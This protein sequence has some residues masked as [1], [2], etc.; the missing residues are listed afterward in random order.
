MKPMTYPTKVAVPLDSS[1]GAMLDSVCTSER[2]SRPGAL[3]NALAFY[4]ANSAT[5]TE[6]MRKALKG[7]NHGHHKRKNEG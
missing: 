1:T 5:V 7:G 3:L 4:F 6:Q 2:R